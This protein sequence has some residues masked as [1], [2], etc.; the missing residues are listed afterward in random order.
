[1]VKS[2]WKGGL[3]W[4]PGC[5]QV[6][7]W[8]IFTL[9][10][11]VFYTL[12]SSVTQSFVLIPC[13]SVLCMSVAVTGLV[14]TALDPTDH[15]SVST[16][17]HLVMCR[18][19][20]SLVRISSKHCRFCDKCIAG[21][22]HHCE[23]LNTCIGRANYRCF[24]SLL[25]SLLATSVLQLACGFILLAELLHLENHSSKWVFLITTL[26]ITQIYLCGL[27]LALVVLLAFHL[28]LKFLSMST[29]EYILNR[30]TNTAK[31]TPMKY[32][33]REKTTNVSKNLSVNDSYMTSK[34]TGRAV[35]N[36]QDEGN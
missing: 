33:S 34:N 11:T 9:Q 14:C 26:A 1:M 5:K 3:T 12:E 31:I 29:Y 28:R 25:L 6:L 22:D 17:E 10:S 36:S 19:C 21:F 20:N 2:I 4:P 35:N 13:Y 15:P 30:R 27:V 7:S 32:I 8:L 24:I 16:T 23:W 18:L